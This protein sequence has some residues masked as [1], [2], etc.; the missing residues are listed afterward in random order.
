MYGITHDPHTGLS[1]DR[2]PRTLKVGIG[3]LAGKDVHVAIRG[4]DGKWIVRVGKNNTAFDTM[5]QAR[6]FYR[7]EKAGAPDRG[8]PTKLPYFTFSRVAPDGGLEPDFDAIMRH[9]PTPTELDVVFA[10]DEPLTQAFEMWSAGGLN[11]KG[12]GVTALRSLSMDPSKQNIS[13]DGKTF[14]I[15]N[16]CAACG[17]EY[18]N[19]TMKGNKEYPAACKPHARL[20]FQLVNDIRLGGKAVF[21]TTSFRSINNLYSSILALKRFTGG[22]DPECG[23]IAGIPLRMI[24]RPFKTAHKTASGTM[25]SG[26]AYCV[27]LEFR[28]QGIEG[29]RKK[30]LAYGSEFRAVMTAELPEAPPVRQIAASVPEG[31]EPEQTEVEQAAAFTAE[32]QPGEIPLDA[33]DDEGDIETSQATGSVEAAQAV[34]ARKLEEAG[35]IPARRDDGPETPEEHDAR[36]ERQSQEQLAAAKAREAQNVP[37]MDPGSKAFKMRRK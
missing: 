19:P 10:D 4:S 15:V 34:A 3:E 5:E 2:T 24:L 20:A 25:Q 21:D 31:E 6:L 28:A 33:E 17:C 22:G 35:V 36:L 30:I 7:K 18:R 16:G 32:F 29:I 37:D 11:C 12:D 23:F 8:F 14:P 9:G 1:I 26:K 27:S 13:F